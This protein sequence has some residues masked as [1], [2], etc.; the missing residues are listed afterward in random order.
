M[1]HKTSHCPFGVFQTVNFR[2][3][4]KQITITLGTIIQP[5][6]LNL[7]VRLYNIYWCMICKSIPL[8][9]KDLNGHV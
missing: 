2:S 3:M 7:Q 6:C 9:P 8:D 5:F 1:F 4:I